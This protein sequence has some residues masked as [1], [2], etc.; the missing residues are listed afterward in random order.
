MKKIISLNLIF[1]AIFLTVPLIYAVSPASAEVVVIANKDV[2]TDSLTAN[3]LMNIFLGKKS[4][5]DDGQRII[6]ATL[7]SGKTHEDFIKT[8][9]NKSSSQFSNYWKKQ[10]FTGKGKLPEQFE[11]EKDLVKYVASTKG[12]IGYI[13]TGTDN[14]PVK[15]ITVR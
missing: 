3:T 10:V 8:Y 4:S 5:W 15:I 13:S 14:S 2:Q 12:A 1:T 11:S 9:V 6:F 7:K